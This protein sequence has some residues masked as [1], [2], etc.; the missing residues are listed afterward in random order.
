MPFSR[1]YP[2][3]QMDMALADVSQNFHS[4]AAVSETRLCEMRLD[5]LRK[6]IR[7]NQVTFPSQVPMFTKHDRPDL[8]QKL[9]QLYFILGWSAA[10]IG[11]RFGISRLRVQQILNTWKRR[12]VE[13]GY[14]QTVPP[15]ESL[16]LPSEHPPIHLV[17]SPRGSAAASA[18]VPRKVPEEYNVSDSGSGRRRRRR[19]DQAEILNILKKLEAGGTIDEMADE[20][21]V[22][23]STIRNWKKQH[24]MRS[25]QPEYVQ[26]KSL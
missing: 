10:K 23:P 8:Q 1:G 4:H 25:L 22:A 5:H 3:T 18:P 19:I 9:T 7:K 14:I 16:R 15:V 26:L 12:A 11:A 20:A 6:A 13:V 17:L 24:E 21:G 2:Q